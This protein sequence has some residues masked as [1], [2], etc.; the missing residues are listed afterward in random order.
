MGVVGTVEAEVSTVE[1]EGRMAA[2]VK[3]EASPEARGGRT[4]KTIQ[5]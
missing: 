4:A 1:V 5:S 3:T 2:E